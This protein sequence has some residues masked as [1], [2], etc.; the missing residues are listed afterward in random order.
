MTNKKAIKIIEHIIG[1]NNTPEEECLDNEL[2]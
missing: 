2:D 1:C